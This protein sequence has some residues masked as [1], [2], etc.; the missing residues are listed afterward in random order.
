MN[1]ID[2]WGSMSS[3]RRWHLGGNM[4]FPKILPTSKL[5]WQLHIHHE[6]RCISCCFYGDFPGSHVRLP[7]FCCKCSRD[8]WELSI[9]IALHSPISGNDHIFPTQGMFDDFPAG[10]RCDGIYV[11]FFRSFGARKT[12]EMWRVMLIYHSKSRSCYR[13]TYFP[14]P[15]HGTTFVYLPTNLPNKNQ[16]QI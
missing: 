5:T 8:M 9:P 7:C 6:W 13:K 1:G 14:W 12:Q 2:S 11:F 10:S 16:H 3:I 15:I 4:W